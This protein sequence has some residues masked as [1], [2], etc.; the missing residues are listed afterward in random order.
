MSSSKMTFEEFTETV[1]ENIKDYLPDSYRDAQVTTGQFQKLNSSYLG[2]QVRQEEQEAVPTVNLERYYEAYSRGEPGLVN[3]DK[4]LTGIAEDVQGSLGLQTAWLM[5][6]EQVK[7]SL[8]IRVNDV[9][10]NAEALKNLPHQETDGL[11]VS[12][13][14][15]VGGKVDSAGSPKQVAHGA[16]PFPG[17]EPLV[18]RMTHLVGK[19]QH[20][21]LRTR[22]SRTAQRVRE[23][24]TTRK[25]RGTKVEAMG[26]LPLSDCLTRF[27]AIGTGKARDGY[28]EL[29][30]RGRT[31]RLR[32]SHDNGSFE[33][34]GIDGLNG[35]P[36]ERSV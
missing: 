9:Q 8:F 12:Y 2:L 11:A 28:R 33:P 35:A 6:Y 16:L 21:A 13:H 20:R 27:I 7:D 23:V 4:V 5:D 1:K 18:G 31:H 19:Q 36:V 14:V 22:E 15:A 26:D 29:F 17:L 10:E 3:L 24:T 32:T 30:L 34:C 25:G